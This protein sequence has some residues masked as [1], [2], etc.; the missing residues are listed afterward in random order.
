MKNLHHA[1]NPIW[2]YHNLHII[3]K[4]FTAN[5]IAWISRRNMGIGNILHD[6]PHLNPINL[7]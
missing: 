1:G 2:F 7:E 4:I 5:S 3:S 6:N